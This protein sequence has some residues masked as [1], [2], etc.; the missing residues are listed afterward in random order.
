MFY[1]RINRQ[2]HTFTE[3]T[4]SAYFLTSA[5]ERRTVSF[6][7]SFCGSVRR[8]K[9]VDWTWNG[10]AKTLLRPRETMIKGAQ[11][12]VQLERQKMKLGGD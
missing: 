7:A 3:L 12:M 1:V 5:D 6:F 11:R 8:T 9:P 2:S 4:S 10:S